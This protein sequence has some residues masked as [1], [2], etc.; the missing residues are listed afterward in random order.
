VTSVDATAVSPL[1][2]LVSLDNETSVDDVVDKISSLIPSKTGITVR[3]GQ[4]PGSSAP[5]AR[6]QLYLDRHGVAPSSINA[7]LDAHGVPARFDCITLDTA[8][9]DYWLW[10]AL[11]ASHAPS[12]VVVAFNPCIA[13]GVE[14]CIILAAAFMHDD[15]EHY[16]ASFSALCGLGQAKGYRLLHIHD[17]RYLCF[18]RNDIDLPTES[19]I[20]PELTEEQFDA[21]IRHADKTS[22]D[23]SRAPWQ[24]I[25]P[26]L[27]TQQVDIEGLR[28]EV[29]ADNRDG[30][31]YQQRGTFEE[32]ASL[33][34]RFIREEGFSTF[35]DVGANYGFVS[36][37]ARR[38]APDLDIIAI[39][40]DPRLARLVR[41]NFLANG[42]EAPTTI[43]AIAGDSLVPN[44]QF[45]LNPS[46]TLD[47]RVNVAKWQQIRV[48]MIT[49]DSV[50]EGLA[51]GSRTFF[52][53]DTQGF[54]LQVLRGMETCLSSRA[55]WIVKMEFAPDWMVSQ[56]TDPLTVLEYLQ[57]RYEFA[58]FPARIPYGTP[59]LDALF[60]APLQARQHEAFLEYVI[61]L[62]K[63]GL[64]WV[65]L[66]V[67]PR[68]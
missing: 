13:L 15:D 59:D 44:A 67:R 18:L 58:E 1:P 25:V 14:A 31:W 65:D 46:S 41:E 52:K 39:E 51:A 50:L 35:V 54:E 6:E 21:L 40:A 30:A 23:V 33:L 48:P 28:V 8:G 47:N 68:R 26:P 57:Q 27:K 11:D 61:S 37:L 7:L 63:R 5:P 60:A 45:S 43:N 20:G 42:L 22:I 24:I 29:L 19:A 17:S 55:G 66:I 56:G 36:M 53:I 62:N 49:V 16:A 32:K 3:I 12:L 10:D 4:R 38:A 9:M 2:R 34:Y 64:G